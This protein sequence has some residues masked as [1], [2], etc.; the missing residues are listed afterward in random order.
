VIIEYTDT[1][2][3]QAKNFEKGVGTVTL[4]TSLT[5][6]T[7][8]RTTV[9]ST[10]GSLN[11]TG[12]PTYSAPSAV[13]IG[14]SA[15]VLV[16]IGPS[17]ADVPS[18]SPYYE[19]TLSGNDNLGVRPDCVAGGGTA[20][21][22]LVSLTDYYSI[23]RLSVPM[24]VK[25]CSIYV[26]TGSGGGTSSAYARIYQINSSGRP[27]KL[28]VDFV[29]FSA[30]NCLNTS[31][32]VI[33]TTALSTGFLLL[34]GEYYFDFLPDFSTGS[35]KVQVVSSS[36]VFGNCR[37]GEIAFLPV[38]QTTATSGTAGAA[39]DPANSTGY[40]ASLSAFVNLFTL[41]VS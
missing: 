1:T 8:A 20:G 11:S 24:L 37:M 30:T 35:P 33:S 25:R 15:N 31:S 19:N 5:A 14:T 23:F 16:F 4:G 13:S 34:P 26:S 9:Q 38:L 12:A 40:A 22:T 7:L 27:G 21:A 6:T 17:A 39:P 36:Y 10:A 41:N 29:A 32:T 2:F 28:L 3:S 18:F